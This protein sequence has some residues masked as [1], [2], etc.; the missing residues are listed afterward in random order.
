MTARAR[1]VTAALLLALVSA[2]PS[3]A[4]G[5]GDPVAGHDFAAKICAQCH[6]IEKGYQPSPEPFAPTFEAIANTPGMSPMALS[7]FLQ[8]PHATMPN[9]VLTA[10]ER[11]N[12]IAYITSL[13]K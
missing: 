8:T 1:P 11:A 2:A 3:Q 13:K 12:I 4:Q 6:G 10:T 9:L 7:V 5:D